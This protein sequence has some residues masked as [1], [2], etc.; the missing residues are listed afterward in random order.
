MVE[1][2]RGR[3]VKS[4]V[5]GLR[6]SS[7]RVNSWV[8]RYFTFSPPFPIVPI[9]QLHHYHQHQFYYWQSHSIATAKDRSAYLWGANL[10]LS[11]NQYKFAL[12]EPPVISSRA[13]LSFLLFSLYS[14]SSSLPLS[15]SPALYFFVK[16]NLVPSLCTSL[17][18][19]D[20][21]LSDSRSEGK[22]GVRFE[23]DRGGKEGG[24]CK[25]RDDNGDNQ[26]HWTVCRVR[27]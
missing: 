26:P 19:K 24:K 14:F 1:R 16:E 12:Y 4:M 7:L 21:P 13:C 17:F 22:D 10:E 27:L 2:R 15:Y 6:D 8:Q 5:W 25:A 23:I 3:R 20:F 9:S 18:S 11:F